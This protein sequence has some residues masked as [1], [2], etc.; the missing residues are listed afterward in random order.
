MNK[1]HTVIIGGIFF[2][3]GQGLLASESAATIVTNT[4]DENGTMTS[5][6]KD[7]NSSRQEEINKIADDVYS[8]LVPAIAEEIKEGISGA[9]K[10]TAGIPSSFYDSFKKE[11]LKQ[12]D[13]RREDLAERN[14]SN[15][16]NALNTN[17]AYTNT[18]DVA[19]GAYA[20]TKTMVV[21]KEDINTSESHARVEEVTKELDSL[22]VKKEDSAVVKE[23][24]KMIKKAQ[25]IIDQ[26]KADEQKQQKMLDELRK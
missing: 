2:L 10:S 7:A 24:K 26:A 1:K 12:G 19:S 17:S 14:I 8:I 13:K 25:A 23:A 21:G 4:K 9:I 6:G 22:P 18:K 16:S 5:L 15:L 3:A 11:L 20:A